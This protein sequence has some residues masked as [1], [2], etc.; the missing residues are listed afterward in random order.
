MKTDSI[1]RELATMHDST[2]SWQ[3][4]GPSGGYIAQLSTSQLWDLMGL[5][6]NIFDNDPADII[7]D[8]ETWELH[9]ED[10][11]I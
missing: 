10:S 3:Q 1:R 8:Y 4:C 9:G 2:D 11:F 6:S 5:R 7:S